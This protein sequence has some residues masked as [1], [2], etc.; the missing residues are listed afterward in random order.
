MCAV[1]GRVACASGGGESG[2]GEWCAYRAGS[3]AGGEES[4][5]GAG[6]WET[7]VAEEEAVELRLL[8]FMAREM[9]ERVEL[10]RDPGERWMR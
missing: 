8:G 3:R 2:G 10:R 9:A 6:D 1:A 7:S 4:G 5:G